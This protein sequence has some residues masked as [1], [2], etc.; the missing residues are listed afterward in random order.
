MTGMSTRERAE[1]QRGIVRLIPLM[2]VSALANIGTR[3]SAIA[4]PW[5][6]LT[7]TN[8]PTATALVTAFELGPYVAAK[9][10]GGPIVDRVGQ[11]R[12]SIWADLISAVII[13]AIPVLAAIGALKLPLLLIL[14]ALAGALRGPGDN[15]KHTLVPLLAKDSGVRLERA[16]GLFGAIERGSGLVAPGIAALMI[17]LFEPTGAVAVNAACIALA[18][19][20]ASAF[21]QRDV[22]HGAKPADGASEEPT[23]SYFASLVEGFR[24]LARDRVLL[25]LTLMVAVTNLFDIAKV[26]VLLPVWAKESGNGIAAISLL[27]TCFAALSVASSLL[28]SWLGP[29]LPRRA[30]YFAGFLLCGP[31]PFLVLGLDLPLWSIAVVYGLGGF[32]SG[33]LNPILGAVFYERIPHHLL[34]RVGGLSDA[35]A[36][37]GMPFG[38]L[39]GAGLIAAAGLGPAF[40]IISAGYLL[41]TAIPGI[42]FPS[43]FERADGLSAGPTTP[44]TEEMPARQ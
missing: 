36:W 16:T 4:I 13:G 22:D 12:V 15:A 34:G 11:R 2:S 39:V 33:F 44:A 14:V 17:T 26:A 32:A 25:T 7:T 3:V 8:S 30:V 35:V 41:A 21:I 38:G 6:V 42:A 28:A 29:R 37:A 27:L 23:S 9:A 43:L 19:L 1:T 31:P 24:F 20:I 40:L 5:L 10:L 18:A